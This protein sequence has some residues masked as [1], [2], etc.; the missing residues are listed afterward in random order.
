MSNETINS[1]Y[2]AE[3]EEG[4][5]YTNEELVEVKQIKDTPFMAIKV[6]DG[7]FLA[8]GK[9]RLSGILESEE[10]VIEDAK[11]TTWDRLISVFLIVKSLNL[12]EVTGTMKA[13]KP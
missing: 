12:D 3:N 7:W 2:S 4:K 6:G 10:A 11:V 13:L 1:N 9:Y 8:L 5:K